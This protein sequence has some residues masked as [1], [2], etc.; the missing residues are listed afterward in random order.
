MEPGYT[1]FQR[2][3]RGEALARDNDGLVRAGEDARLL[4]PLYQEQGEDGFF[5]VREF[6]PIWMSVSRWLRRAGAARWAVALPG[7]ERL[8][9]GVDEVIVDKRVARYFARQLFHL[10]GYRQME[11]AGSRLIMRRR[12][13]DQDTR[14]GQ[15]RPFGVEPTS[16]IA[17]PPADGRDR[18]DPSEP[19]DRRSSGPPK[20]D[21]S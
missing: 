13:F 16:G 1:N 10:L 9:G 7:V 4:M 3:A 17:G 6:K 20:S 8:E 12:S 2:V 11:D 19:S 21:G 5:L 15:V 18:R 14:P